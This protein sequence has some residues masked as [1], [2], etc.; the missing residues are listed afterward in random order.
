MT[1]NTLASDFLVKGANLCSF[2]AQEKG[3]K[4][5]TPKLFDAICTLCE[6]CSGLSNG[7]VSKTELALLRKNSSLEAGKILLHLSALYMSGC[8]SSA[9]RE[10]MQQTLD[11]LKKDFNI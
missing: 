8:I 11:A 3:E 1:D 7:T 2:L 6:Y 9:Q 4:F 5:I 10:S